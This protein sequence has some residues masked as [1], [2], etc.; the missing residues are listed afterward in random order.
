MNAAFSEA[1]TTIASA[2]SSGLPP[3][4]SG[5]AAKNAAFLSAEPVSRSSIAVSVGPGATAF[6][7]TPNG[8]ASRAADSVM[9]STACLLPV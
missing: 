9:P 2:I 7:R 5:T 1:T 6:T 8:A 3:R 4:F